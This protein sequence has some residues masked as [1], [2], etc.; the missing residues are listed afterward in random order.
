LVCACAPAAHAGLGGD[1]A[2]ILSDTIDMQG[3]ATAAHFPAYEVQEIVTGGGLRVREYVSGGRVFAVA[4]AGPVMPDMKAVLGASFAA[5]AQHLASL[6][7]PGLHRSIRIATADL[8]LESA[9]HMRAYY[10]RAYLPA[11]APAALSVA[12][13]R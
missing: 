3:V 2:S 5:Y 7:H 11:L 10:G 4:W 12:E 9:G 8:V 6:D 1:A 13:L